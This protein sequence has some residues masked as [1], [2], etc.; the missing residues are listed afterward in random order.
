MRDD[1]L[2]AQAP[3]AARKEM[4][5]LLAEIPAGRRAERERRSGRGTPDPRQRAEISRTYQHDAPHHYQ[6]QGFKGGGSR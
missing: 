5:G 6:R 1:N 3:I 4:D 2:I